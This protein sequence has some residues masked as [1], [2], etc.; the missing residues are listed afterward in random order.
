MASVIDGNMHWQKICP[1]TG[2][3]WDVVLRQ[4]ENECLLGLP[5]WT[6]GEN[7]EKVVDEYFFLNLFPTIYMSEQF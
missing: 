2:V 6:G 1:L 4:R 5:R 7:N 3:K